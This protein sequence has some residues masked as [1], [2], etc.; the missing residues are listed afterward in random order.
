M[1]QS[2]EDPLGVRV[3]NGC[4]LLWQWYSHREELSKIV[5]NKE[6]TNLRCI[7]NNWTSV[8]IKKKKTKRS[9]SVGLPYWRGHF[10]FSSYRLLRSPTTAVVEVTERVDV[11]LREVNINI[12]R[13]V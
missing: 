13:L 8:N 3:S 11:A 12:K 1:E 4:R 9:L 2:R 5:F 7:L 10:L 6:R